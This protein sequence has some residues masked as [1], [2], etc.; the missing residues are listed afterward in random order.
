[1]ADNALKYGDKELK[2]FKVDNSSLFQW[3][4][5]SGGELPKE[6]KGRFT[7][8]RE[9]V[10]AV[11]KANRRREAAV[12][13]AVQAAEAEAAD[14]AEQEAIKAEASKIAAAKRKPA[15]KKG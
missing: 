9:A 11:D 8:T 14:L 4:F 7:G 6:L 12:R 13:A 15:V 2:L 5:T 3:S 10:D 1:M